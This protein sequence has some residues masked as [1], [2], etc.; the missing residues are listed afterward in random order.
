M[1][2]LQACS[3]GITS[4]DE[5]LE[6]L[7]NQTSA[8]ATDAPAIT[9][10][11]ANPTGTETTIPV[12]PSVISNYIINNISILAPSSSPSSPD[13]ELGTEAPSPPPPET[14]PEVV[15]DPPPETDPEVVTDPPPE[16]DPEVVTDPPPETDPEVVTDPP[17][18]TDPEIVTDPPPETDPEIVTDPP[19]ETD[20]EVVTD[21]PPETD[22]EVVTDPPPETDPDLVTD[23]PSESEGDDVVSV[24]YEPI[25]KAPT[26]GELVPFGSTIQFVWSVP[27]AVAGTVTGFDIAITDMTD[28]VDSYRNNISASSS[29]NSDG[30][31]THEVI[32]TDLPIPEGDNAWSV[33]SLGN[34]ISPNIAESSFTL[35]EN[36]EVPIAAGL[37]LLSPATGYIADS[38]SVDF[39]WSDPD[40]PDAVYDL[41]VYSDA[42]RTQ[43]VTGTNGVIFDTNGIRTATSHTFTDD[44][45]DGTKRYGLLWQWPDAKYDSELRKELLFEYTAFTEEVTSA[46]KTAASDLELDLLAEAEQ[47]YS[48]RLSFP[49]NKANLDS[50][51]AYFSANSWIG[52]AKMH[53][54]T[55][56]T[57]WLQYG[58]SEVLQYI[59]H[60]TDMD[61]DGYKD[62]TNQSSS[63]SP[64]INRYHHEIRG[65][66]GAAFV[67][68]ELKR[69][70]ASVT[71]SDAEMQIRDFL[72]FHVWQKWEN[73]TPPPGESNLSTSLAWFVGRAATVAAILAKYEPDPNSN[74]Y[75][76][77]INSGR[78]KDLVDSFVRNYDSSTDSHMGD[79]WVTGGRK[80]PEY[81][82]D[83]SHWS[84]GIHALEMVREQG[85]NGGGVVTQQFMTRILNR[86][87]NVIWPKGGLTD[88]ANYENGDHDG[89]VGSG[90]N[91]SFGPAWS[92]LSSLDP[93]FRD[94]MITWAL[95]GNNGG[96]GAGTAFKEAR[97][98]MIA[99]LLL[100][101]Q[102]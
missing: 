81:V 91:L 35:D 62:W 50:Y 58:V 90:G 20:P 10:G 7:S 25:L 21:P 75:A 28:G 56:D 47:L 33:S 64:Y 52:F 66:M 77:F 99:G 78:F 36:H 86:V 4:A 59:N 14:N 31:C 24:N 94:E 63:T 57:K 65:A 49:H 13:E 95:Y 68:A 29:C 23:T 3:E 85:F 79:W 30:L 70:G 76:T 1:F 38:S 6:N 17:P 71:P 46:K 67:L 88:W 69:S 101:G 93:T 43:K 45:S 97:L 16:T 83:I 73:V 15:T 32:S 8:E 18:E 39:S 87:K 55:S 82:G 53:A 9:L 92:Y 100:A 5:A 102:Q 12:T 96:R 89:K 44:P 22:P 11:A 60:G 42:A 2:A 19:P 51:R 27:A 80:A 37:S 54:Y 48:E 41:H 74:K 26:E 98:E 40:K 84:D 61:G 34:D 72:R